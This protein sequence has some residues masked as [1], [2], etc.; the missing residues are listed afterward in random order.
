M[1]EH[2]PP[3]SPKAPSSVGSKEARPKRPPR[4]RYFRNDA[5]LSR[6]D[7]HKQFLASLKRLVETYPPEKVAPGGGLYYGPISIAYAFFTFHRL[8]PETEVSGK[9][10]GEWSAAYITHAQAFMKE[11]PGPSPAKC[12]ISD[13]IMALLALGAASAKDADMA[14]ELC[15][16]ADEVLDEGASNEWLYGRAG[17]LYL[18][19]LVRASFDDDDD[20]GGGGATKSL[21]DET[22]QEV[23]ETILSDPR[24]WKWHGKAYIGA[25]HGAIGII[26]QIVLT[27]A[28][29]APKLEPELGALL[30]YQYPSGN[31]PSSIP[32]TRDKYVQFCHG[33]AGFVSSLLTLR[34]YFPHLAPRIDAAV[35]KGRACVL[36][37][38][39]LTKEPCLCHG[40]SG[41]AL[42]LEKEDFEH[43]L[44][45]TTGHEIRSMEKDGMMERSEDP[46]SLWCGEAG[47]A[48]AWA[49]ADK[50]LE[51]TFLGFNDI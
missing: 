40:I 38:G 36:E 10:M 3:S 31:F 39:L 35:A 27:D 28:K 13:D 48:W 51:R 47:R 46:A 12:G 43:F 9:T 4:P 32:P 49:V 23:I 19:R 20:D 5:P 22:A 45:Y 15:E 8:Y 7:P 26:T 44:S 41:N 29:Y 25:V 50:G 14:K 2:P 37:R 1:A 18:L 24:P 42:V 34:P 21:L 11:Y 16:C 33:A 30:S 17:F 6:R